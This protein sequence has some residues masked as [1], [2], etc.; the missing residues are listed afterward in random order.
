MLCS[1][2]FP[3]ATKGLPLLCQ[4]VALGTVSSVC[5]E[6]YHAGSSKS[7]WIVIVFGGLS[8]DSGVAGDGEREPEAV[9]DDEDIVCC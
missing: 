4:A 8:E 3:T 2:L 7:F 1:S 9:A 5:N 6:P